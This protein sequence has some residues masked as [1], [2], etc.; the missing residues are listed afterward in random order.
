M[1][2]QIQVVPRKLMIRTKCFVVFLFILSVFSLFHVERHGKPVFEFHLI[3]RI[4]LLFTAFCHLLYFL[5]SNDVL[6]F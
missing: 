3:H 1:E 2:D 6:H 5:S 4:F